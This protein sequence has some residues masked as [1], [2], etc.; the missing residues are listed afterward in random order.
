MANVD[1]NKELI[2]FEYSY[3]YNRDISKYIYKRDMK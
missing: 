2:G 3:Y 1:G